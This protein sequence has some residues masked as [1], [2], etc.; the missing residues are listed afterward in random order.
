MP[1][2]P[3]ELAFAG[4]GNDLPS[5]W[6]GRDNFAIL[7]T[8]FGS[9]T[10]FLSVWQAW[11]IDPRRPR[12]LHYFAVERHPLCREDLAR[13]HEAQPEFAAL[14]APLRASWP[15]RVTGFHRLHFE[16]GA[17][18][19]TL[20]FGD[21]R[22]AIPGIAG[23]FDAIHHDGLAPEHNPQ[24]WPQSLIDDLAWL[25]DPENRGLSP[26]SPI[27][28]G[29]VAV[30]GGGIAGIACA[31]RLVAQGCTVTLFE[32]RVTFAAETSGN[33]QA[34]L[35]PVLAVDETRLAR[36]NRVAFL[37][38]LR[39]LRELEAAGHPV[40][41]QN[42]GVFQIARDAEHAKKQ[43]AIVHDQRLP[44]DFVRFIDAD[45]AERR[46]GVRVAGP[47]W[48]F[49][50]AGWL[51]PASLAD[52]LLAAAGKGIERR[53]GVDIATLDAH[54]DEWILRDA[55]GQAQW[56]GATVVLAHAHGIRT[57]AQAA[58]LPIR[59]FRGQVTHLPAPLLDGLPKSVVCREG[60][61]AP[62]YKTCAG[63]GATFQRSHDTDATVSDHVSNLNR[64]SAMLP[65]WAGRFDPASLEGRVGLRPVSPDKLP[66]VGALPLPVCD[67]RPMAHVE[68]PRWPGLHVASGYGA[69]GFVWAPLMGELLASQITGTPLPIEHE[70]AAAV[71]PA[72]FTWKGTV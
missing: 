11:Q 20:I 64:L 10:H 9:G 49:P 38:V 12:R 21:V 13:L 63:L 34:I 67:P 37:Y 54:G 5:R 65:D 33:H 47:G 48:W 2:T 45:E 29:R 26:I 15:S 3:A 44:E 24:Q 40:D 43:A 60:Y 4:D 22:T 8:S 18:T 69:R 58:H 56:Q 6:Q 42:C 59:C 70:L 66:I 46:T 55:A 31:E 41:G 27:S 17:V 14:S 1:L 23:H 62:A 68:W 25:T 51:S 35:L 61:L 53:P 19:L 16:G 36:L 28:A 72:R 57:L 30:V 71:D 52:A 32:R 50:Q 39:R 7:A